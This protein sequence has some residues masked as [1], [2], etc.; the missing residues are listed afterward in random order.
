[1]EGEVLTGLPA[2]LGLVLGGHGLAHD[3]DL[4][5]LDELVQGLSHEA[6]HALVE[7]LVSV[8]AL[9]ELHRGHSF[10]ESFDIGLALIFI[11]ALAQRLGIICRSNLDGHLI[12]KGIG[13]NMSYIH[14]IVLLYFLFGGAKLANFSQFLTLALWVRDASV[15]NLL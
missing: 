7:G 6:V 9:D 1:M 5:V 8:H 2:Q 13:L 4:V 14:D 15:E 10:A 3:A 11:E 12:I